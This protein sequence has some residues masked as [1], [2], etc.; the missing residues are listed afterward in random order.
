MRFAALEAMGGLP[1]AE[2]RAW[3]RAISRE[4]GGAFDSS[5]LA[6]MGANPPPDNAFP[7]RHGLNPWTRGR[8]RVGTGFAVM[9]V[10]RPHDGEQHKVDGET[11]MIIHRVLAAAVVTAF[12]A[13]PAFSAEPLTAH[14]DKDYASTLANYQI[15]CYDLMQQFDHAVAKMKSTKKVKSGKLMRMRGEKLCGA[16]EDLHVLKKGEQTLEQALRDI[17]QKPRS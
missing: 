3:R 13:S 14:H 16:E 9:E 15:H 1:L 6:S 7:Q 10:F 12:A 2:R 8:F 17:G 5:S 11:A 4:E